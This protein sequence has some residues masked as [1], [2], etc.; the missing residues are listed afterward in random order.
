MEKRFDQRR[1]LNTG[2]AGGMGR[3]FALAFAREG[4]GLI[5]TDVEQQGLE[6]TASLVRAEGAECSAHRVN[7]AGESEIEQFA[8]QVCGAHSRLAVLV[9]NAGLAYGEVARAFDG[10]SQEK[11]PP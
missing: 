5:V 10:H 7:L 3:T 6:E 11:R 2:A 4:A 8:D 1:V 9:N